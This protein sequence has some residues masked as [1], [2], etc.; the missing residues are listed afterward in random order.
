MS[1]KDLLLFGIGGVALYYLWSSYSATP[2]PV[3]VTPVNP[4]LLPSKQT[5]VLTPGN[6]LLPGLT[7]TS[8]SANYSTT[9]FSGT[10]RA[11]GGF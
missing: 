7:P 10:R 2:A 5:P 6:G 8:A 4:L 9:N 3:V 1:T 11:I